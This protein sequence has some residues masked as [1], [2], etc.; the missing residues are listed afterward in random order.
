LE[1]WFATEVVF[2]RELLVESA[3]LEQARMRRHAGGEEEEKRMMNDRKRDISES[4]TQSWVTVASLSER[5]SEFVASA[6]GGEYRGKS[7]DVVM[8]NAHLI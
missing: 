6:E 2:F 1:N 7:Q 3:V 4:S 5:R 8:G